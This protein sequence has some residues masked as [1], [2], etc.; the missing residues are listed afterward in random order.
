MD[1]SKQI[2]LEKEGL[3]KQSRADEIKKS[4]E[5]IIAEM[6]GR[7][8]RDEEARRGNI[9]MRNREGVGGVFSI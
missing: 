5:F 3:T 7:L 9:L 4:G 6:S 1:Q 2:G 8:T